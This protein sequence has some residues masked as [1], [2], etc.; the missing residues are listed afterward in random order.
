MSEGVRQS[1]DWRK[2][3]PKLRMVANGSTAVNVRRAEHAAAVAVSEH[4][5]ESVPAARAQDAAPMTGVGL[6]DVGER[7]HLKE[8][9]TAFVSLFVQLAPRDVNETGVPS[10][11][12][13]TAVRGDLATAELPVRDALELRTRRRVAAVE[14]GQPLAAP[15]PVVSPSRV[16]APSMAERRFGDARRH[17]NGAGVLIGLVDVGGF[18]FAHSDFIV[19]GKLRGWLPL[20]RR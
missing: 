15:E 1:S 13:L 14:L 12:P 18:D 2:L 11:V 3:Q 17:H 9:A 10:G 8:P 20:L 16:K 19:D 6:K 4:E 7:G 5:A